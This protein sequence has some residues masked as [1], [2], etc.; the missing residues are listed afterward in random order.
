[1]KR[2]VIWTKAFKKD[3]KLAIKRGMKI[4]LLDDVIRKLSRGEALPVILC[5]EGLDHMPRWW[6]DSFAWRC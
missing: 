4:E 5:Q 1:M 3:Y 6:G 2:D